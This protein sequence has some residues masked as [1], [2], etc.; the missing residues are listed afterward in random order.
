LAELQRWRNAW[1]EPGRWELTQKGKE[2]TNWNLK[3]LVEEAH[4]LGIV[5]ETARTQADLLRGFRNL[6]HPGRAERKGQKCS[7]ATAYVAV[8]AVEAVVEELRRPCS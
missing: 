3:Q 4:R 6:I 5:S 8:A 7:R 2:T 1:G